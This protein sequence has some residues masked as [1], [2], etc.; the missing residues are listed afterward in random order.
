MSIEEKHGVL[1][2]D[3][4]EGRNINTALKYRL[5]RRTKEVTEGILSYVGNSPKDIIDFGTAEGKMLNELSISF[6]D[7]NC[8][9]VEYN[10]DLVELG[11]QLFPHLNI[12]Q[13]DLENLDSLENNKYDV[14]V[15]T[16]VIEHLENPFKFLEDAYRVLKPEGIIIMTA[17]DPFWEHIATMVGH[18]EDE[19]HH[20][21]PNLK[22]L[23]EY[24]SV[25]NF[26]ILK[27]QKFML[28]PI[29][30]PAEIF[31]EK[32]VRG[33]GCNFLFANQLV[34][35]RKPSI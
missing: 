28:S 18:L 31:I 9:G 1:G 33:L 2:K 12:T 25:S 32:L 24:L 29:G 11:K 22:R 14:A 7:A 3:Y 27:A 20:E 6:P 13:G 30:L 4:A 34:I 26:D 8:T 35:G 17:P 5:L 23:K 19:Q 16:A 21:V 15:A 10:P